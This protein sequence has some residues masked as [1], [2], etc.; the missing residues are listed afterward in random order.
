MDKANNEHME[1]RITALEIGQE[2]LYREVSS[3]TTAVKDQGHQLTQSIAKLSEQVSNHG[4]TDWTTFWTMIMAGLLLLTA[5]ST[6]VWITFTGVEKNSIRHDN[7]LA[8]IEGLTVDS[9]KERAELRTK[10][11]NQE[12]IIDK[13]IHI[14]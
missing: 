3:L 8:R 6:P 13:L 4:K 2:N 9:I 12:K 11:E 7:E 10:I 5:I 14:R 1:P